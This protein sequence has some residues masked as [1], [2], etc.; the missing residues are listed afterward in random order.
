MTVLDEVDRLYELAV[1]SPATLND[2]AIQDWADGVAV[3]YGMDRQAAKYVRRCLNVS[4]KLASF[5]LAREPRGEDPPD[6]RSRVDLALGVRAWRP[7]L[8]LAQH[9]LEATSSQETYEHAARL[10]RV[11][12]NEPFLDGMS[13]DVWL[14]TRQN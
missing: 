4:R 6:W 3:G 7:E 9:L 11:V 13:Y 5:W 2:Q 12:N 10:F 1:T 14:G 8:E